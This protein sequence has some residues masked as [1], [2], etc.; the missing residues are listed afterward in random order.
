[1]VVSTDPITEKNPFTAQPQATYCS[2]CGVSPETAAETERHEHPEAQA[3]RD[4]HEERHDH[5]HR[6]AVLQPIGDGVEAEL[7]EER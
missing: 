7:V 2:A 4:E 1:M 3:E 6:E 5:T